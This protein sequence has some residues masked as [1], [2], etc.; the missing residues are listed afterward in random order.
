[1]SSVKIFVLFAA[2]VVSFG[3]VL[4]FGLAYGDDSNLRS[5]LAQANAKLISLEK[6]KKEAVENAKLAE[7]AADEAI[8]RAQVAQAETDKAKA[9]VEE[10]RQKVHVEVING[11]EYLPASL[12]KAQEVLISNLE[13]ELKEVKFALNEKD[14]ALQAM[15]KAYESSE[16]QRNLDK[17]AMEASKAA[18]KASRNQGRIEGFSVGLATTLVA[19]LLL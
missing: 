13:L 14:K 3:S 5:Q 11:V 7:L 4:A 19:V 15:K 8:K 2:L 10:E 1:M 6:E 12:P 16:A 9:K 18:I 17:I